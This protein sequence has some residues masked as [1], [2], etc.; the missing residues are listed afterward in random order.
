M[1]IY[2]FLSILT[3]LCITI[4]FAAPWTLSNLFIF[5]HYRKFIFAFFFKYFLIFFSSGAP[6]FLMFR[7]YHYL[8]DNLF[9]YFGLCH[10]ACRILILWPVIKPLVPC[11]GR[12]VLTA[13]PL[14]NSHG[15]YIYIYIYILKSSIYLIFFVLDFGTVYQS[16]FQIHQ[17]IFSVESILLFIPL[18][19]F[20]LF[21]QLQSPNIIVLLCFLKIICFALLIFCLLVI[22]LMLIFFF[23][24]TLV[25][26][27]CSVLDGYMFLQFVDFLLR[28]F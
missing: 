10:Q 5:F 16:N 25:H 19:W 7:F 11:S 15:V 21:Q 17:F 4:M 24:P 12:R 9:I 20:F 13:G 1:L 14:D 3:S 18:L 28:L 26:L 8:V 2:L 23:K 6:T 22:L 27:L